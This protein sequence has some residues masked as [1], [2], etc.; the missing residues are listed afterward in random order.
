QGTRTVLAAWIPTCILAVAVPAGPILRSERGAEWV[1]AAAGMPMGQ[2]RLAHV[3]LLATIGA[4]KGLVAAAALGALLAWDI[5]SRCTLAIAVAS[6]GALLAGSTAL[7]MRWALR[8]TGHDGARAVG[9]VLAL[10]A[11]AEAL[12]YWI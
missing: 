11:V 7:A 10:V 4:I 3:G 6:S 9:A 1:L 12:L 2:R 8:D 5:T